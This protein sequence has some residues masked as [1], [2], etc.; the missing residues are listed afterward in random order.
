MK[1]TSS[2]LRQII[3]EEIQKLL[4][5]DREDQAASMAT[6]ASKLIKALEAFQNVASEKAKSSSDSRNSSLMDHLK[7]AE[8]ILKRVVA[9]PLE[10]VDGPKVPSSLDNVQQ[11]K[12]VSIQPDLKNK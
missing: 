10:Y 9:S 12:K 7:S 4:E 6:A 8:K 3:N 2:K 11:P 1:I 5:G